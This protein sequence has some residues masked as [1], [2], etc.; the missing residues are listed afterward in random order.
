V[1]PD[2][3]HQEEVAPRRGS[4]K[5]LMVEDEEA[6]LQLGVD[7]LEDSGYTVLAA[8]TPEEALRLMQEHSVSVDLI[9]TDVVMPKMNGKEL[10]KQI[11]LLHPGIKCLFMSGYTADIIA[12]QGVLDKDIFFIQKPF[13]LNSLTVMARQVLENDLEG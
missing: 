9:I 5:I 1:I 10:V 6:L 7:A 2:R 12:D 8:N 13:S 11:R 4:E 3:P